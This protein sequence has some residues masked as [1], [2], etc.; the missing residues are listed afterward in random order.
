[1]SPTDAL[2]NFAKSNPQ[3]A[4]ILFGAI[5]CFASVAIIASFGIELQASVPNVVYI[6]VI[7]VLLFVL[8]KIVHDAILMSVLAWFVTILAMAWVVVFVLQRMDPGNPRF[9]CLADPIRACAATADDNAKRTAPS[10]PALAAP[11]AAAAS[12]PKR[13]VVNV[14]FAGL[15]RDRVQTFMEQLAQAGWRVQGVAG[16]GERTGTAAGL[17]EV[18]YGPAADA[19]A[20]RA[21]AASVQ[22]SRLTG[23][24]IRAVQVEAIPA[25]SLEIWVSL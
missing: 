21:L 3:A 14:Q 19:E 25:N 23:K 13:Y 24:S 9:A 10:L 6:L 15:V 5:A 16:G 22:A 4:A 7:G 11:A 1:M 20:A 8:V 2:Q 18:R 17:A 12:D